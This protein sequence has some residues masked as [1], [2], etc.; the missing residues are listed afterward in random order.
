M[1]SGNFF[2]VVD[3]VNWLNGS[4]VPVVNGRTLAYQGG[5]LTHGSDRFGTM[6]TFRSS[7][8]QLPTP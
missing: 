7:G 3:G 4:A 8:R 6:R 5:N 1:N 2:V